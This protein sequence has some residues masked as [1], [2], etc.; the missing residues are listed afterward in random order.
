MGFAVSPSHILSTS[1][2]SSG[3]GLFTLIPCSSMGSLPQET[4]LQSSPMWVPPMVC[5]S[6][7]TSKTQVPFTGCSTS[8]TEQCGFPMRSQVLL[9][10]M[11][12]GGLLSSWLQDGLPTGSQSPVGI[13]LLQELQVELCSSM[14]LHGMEEGSLASPW[15]APWAAGEYLLQYLLSLLLCWL[16]N[17][18]S[19]TPS[20]FWLQSQ[21]AFLP[22]LKYVIPGVPPLLPKPS[23]S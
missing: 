2:S 20:S 19:Y 15:S 14:D 22:L 8:R 7:Q 16:Q 5:I 23:P 1:S 11:L 18:L 12:E 3:G 4:V 13:H 9:A 17:C 10:N 6:S 21:R